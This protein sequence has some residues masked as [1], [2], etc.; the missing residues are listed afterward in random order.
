MPKLDWLKISSWN[1][2]GTPKMVQQF[3]SRVQGTPRWFTSLE[4]EQHGDQA[5]RNAEKCRMVEAQIKCRVQVWCSSADLSTSEVIECKSDHWNSTKNSAEQPIEGPAGRGTLKSE[6]DDD[7]L[8]SSCKREEKNR[9]LNGCNQ[10]KGKT[11]SEQTRTE[12][13][14]KLVKGTPRWF[15]NLEQEQNG[16]QEQR[17]A[18]WLKHGS[19]AEYKWMF[20]CRAEYKCSDRVHWHSTKNSTEQPVEG[21]AGRKT[22]RSEDDED[23]LKSSCKRE[24]N[25]RAL[26]G[27]MKQPAQGKDQ[28]RANQNGEKLETEKRVP[29][30]SWTV[31][32]GLRA[33]S[34]CGVV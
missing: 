7:Q 31:Y 1:S 10:L 29:D 34:Y 23:Q 28:L 14:Y 20:K 17:N 25:K 13:S 27:S 9:V 18:E 19:S 33:V 15:T 3:T 11:S 22:L 32:V 4:Q 12:K 5:Q 16:D 8:K 24:E 26:N 6:N 2:K 30:L 21:T